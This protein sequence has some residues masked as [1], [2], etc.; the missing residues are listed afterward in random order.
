M[1]LTHC[2][3]PSTRG[4]IQYCFTTAQPVLLFRSA[5]NGGIISYVG[6]PLVGLGPKL[7]KSVYLGPKCVNSGKE[8]SMA[9]SAS[10]FFEVEIVNS[11]A[12]YR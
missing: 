6:L 4:N 11:S 1:K 12:T 2:I 9:L 5:Q 10:G 7:I 3:Q 8:I